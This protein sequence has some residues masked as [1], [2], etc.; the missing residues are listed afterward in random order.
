MV[1][2]RIL[3]FYGFVQLWL[4]AAAALSIAMSIV[5]KAPNLMINFTF[6]DIDLTG[7]SHLQNTANFNIH[8]LF[9]I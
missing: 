3:G 2:K 8:Q 9:S 7:A 4:L 6:H 5:W 1:S